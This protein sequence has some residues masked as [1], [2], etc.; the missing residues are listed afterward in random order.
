MVYIHA[1]ELAMQAGNAKTANIV[2]FGAYVAHAKSLEKDNAI[3]TIS[4]I[5]AKK[6]KVIPA[7]VSAFEIGNALK[8]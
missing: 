1:N 3:A 2:V 6:P 7:N 5:F 8:E 4:K